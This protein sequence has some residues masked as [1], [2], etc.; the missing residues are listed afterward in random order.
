MDTVKLNE[1]ADLLVRIGLNV[2]KGQSVN[3][4]APIDCAVLARACVKSCYDAGAKSVSVT[5]RDSIVN[6]LFYLYADDS[7]IDVVPE[8][9]LIHISEP[10][11]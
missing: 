7:V 4:F 9:S 1:Y 5:W 10:T 6:R 3:I 8:L 2:Q 11:D